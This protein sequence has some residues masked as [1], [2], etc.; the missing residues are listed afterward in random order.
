MTTR[1]RLACVFVAVFDNC[2]IP[3]SIL[4]SIVSC[5]IMSI[6]SFKGTLFVLTGMPTTG[7]NMTVAEGFVR[8]APPEV[9]MGLLFVC[10]GTVVAVMAKALKRRH[11][12]NSEAQAEPLQEVPL[13]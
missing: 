12:R 13:Q 11:K 10:A 1:E 4:F 7:G 9:F 5:V 8:I 3:A 2:V 6:Y